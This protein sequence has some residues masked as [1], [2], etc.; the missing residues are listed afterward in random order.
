M[1]ITSS[2]QRMWL[3]KLLRVWENT[4]LQLSIA[5]LAQGYSFL[6][7]AYFSVSENAPYEPQIFILEKFWQGPKCKGGH[8]LPH[9]INF[10]VSRSNSQCAR[11]Q[12][13]IWP[14]DLV[15]VKVIGQG[16]RNFYTALR[17]IVKICPESFML[18]HPVVF[19]VAYVNRKC[20]RR[21][22]IGRILTISKDPTVGVRWSPISQMLGMLIVNFPIYTS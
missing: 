19:S 7:L 11:S 3:L 17:L 15:E 6:K 2:K 4:P 12:N 20:L 1:S 16:H 9:V 21:R 10:E 13:V 5:F 14:F 8:G 18:I 22:R